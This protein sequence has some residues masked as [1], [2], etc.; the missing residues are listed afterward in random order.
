[1][2]GD[3]LPGSG[4]G[5]GF[6]TFVG[7]GQL[8]RLLVPSVPF[9][10]LQD[11]DRLVVAWKPLR[12]AMEALQS[13]APLPLLPRMFALWM[14]GVSVYSGGDRA[15][16]F[17]LPLPRDATELVRGRSTAQSRGTGS[18]TKGSEPEPVDCHVFRAAAFY[19]HLGWTGLS[20][21]LRLG[22]DCESPEEVLLPHRS[23]LP[24]SGSMEGV[25]VHA[26]RI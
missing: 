11:G 3:A 25:A 1:M 4:S 6:G 18:E 10:A 14:D 13:D 2:T 24:P 15:H 7:T 16:A 26:D 19:A 8:L 17:A 21:S 9:V 22:R 12:R 5:S 20:A 23:S